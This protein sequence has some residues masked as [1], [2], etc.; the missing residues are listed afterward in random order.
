LLNPV[1]LHRGITVFEQFPQVNRLT[2]L[3]LNSKQLSRKNNHVK[4][5]IINAM[6]KLGASLI[7][8]LICLVSFTQVSANQ[9][10]VIISTPQ[11]DGAI[12]HQ[13]VD[14]DTLFDIAEAYGMTPS[15]IMTL[16]GNSPDATEI[17]I[18]QFL[19]IRRGTVATATLEPAP[20]IAPHTPQPT[21]MQPTRTAIPTKT[22]LPSPTPTTPPST[23]QLL[24]GNSQRL[25]LTL[26]ASS[27]IGI[28]LV[29]I[30]G[31]LRKSK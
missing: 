29:V 13:V 2:G 16:N 1:G 19:L 26:I 27:V 6:K 31:F 7:L 14:G 23:T 17:Y 24:F 30:F 21:V 11:A 25:G 28:A 3:L 12:Y 5:A 4:E 20:T 15:D 22:P 10:G 18:G 8:I 9:A